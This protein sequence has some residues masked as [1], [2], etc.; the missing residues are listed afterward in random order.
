MDKNLLSFLENHKIKYKIHLH[1]P[2]FTVAESKKL[3]AEIPGVF[4]TK[5]LFLKDEAN[6]FF[7]VCMDAHKMLDLKSLKDKI[8]ALKKLRFASEQELRENLNVSPGSV[9]IFAMIYSKNVS[10]IIDKKII[11][12][13]KVGFHPNINT[14]TLEI[15][16]ENLEKYLSNLKC[17]KLVIEL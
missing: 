7:L 8:N 6:N 17:K 16:K 15:N 12:S 2:V 11:E 4:H 13:E 5:N 9:S 3:N 14:A 10:L 1:P